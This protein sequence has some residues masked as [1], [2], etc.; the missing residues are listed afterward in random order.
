MAWTRSRPLTM[1]PARSSLRSGPAADCPASSTGAPLVTQHALD[2]VQDRILRGFRGGRRGCGA[3]DVLPN[4]VVLFPAL[5]RIVELNR[6]PL[7]VTVVPEPAD[8]RGEELGE[9]ADVIAI[10]PAAGE[11][12]Q[13]PL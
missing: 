1:D 2:G 8:V 9:A 12:T 7:G 3:P 10:E 11:G 6:F 5:Q 4:A 13:D